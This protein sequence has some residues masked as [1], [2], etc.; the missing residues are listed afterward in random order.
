M[1]SVPFPDDENRRLEQL[2]ELDLLDT[3]AEDRFDRITRLACEAL[4]VGNSAINLVD[5]ERQWAKSTCGVEATEAPREHSFCARAILDDSITVIPNARLDHQF[6]DNPM[7]TG[8]P[9][10]RFYMGKPIHTAQGF[11]VGT[12]CVF[13]SHPREPSDG[14]KRS[15]EDLAAIVDAEIQRR[16]LSV[17]RS[18]LRDELA[19]A[20]RRSRIDGLTEL[21]NRTAI[22]EL[23]DSEVERSNRQELPV[24]VAMADLDDFKQI[25][26]TH[27]HQAGDKILRT[28]A[29]LIRQAIRDYDV[30]G[31][32]GGEEFVVLFPESKPEAGM[33]VAERIRETIDEEPIIDR[34]LEHEVTISLG[35]ASAKPLASSDAKNLIGEADEAL[36]KAKHEGKNMVVNAT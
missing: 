30:A 21:W 29:E 35:V 14:E 1:G 23:I 7:V 13:D 33:A 18:R 10:I 36:Y 28:V 8:D 31:R 19:E 27:G 6:Q 20:E 4:G 3:P 17:E 9:H 25:N 32:Y 22:L 11:R 5:A 16:K 26:D 15:L 2:K 24:S 34:G 12:L